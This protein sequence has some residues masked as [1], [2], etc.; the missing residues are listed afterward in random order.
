MTTATIN[1]IKRDDPVREAFSGCSSGNGPNRYYKTKGHALCAYDAALAD[2]GY[3]FDRADNYA[4]SGDE[5]RTTIDI[6]VG[7]GGCSLCVGHAVIYY[8]RMESG[9]YEFIGYIA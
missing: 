8:F 1:T 6:Y 9:R 3:H 5:G 4:W 7:G 2:F